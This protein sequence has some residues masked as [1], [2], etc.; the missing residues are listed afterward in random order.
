MTNEH[1]DTDTPTLQGIVGKIDHA[2]TSGR[3]STGDLAELRRISPDQPYTPALWKVLLNFVPESWTAGGGRDEKERRWAT[4]LMAMGM[5]AGLHDPS[6]RFG[7]ALARAG[8]S[9]L[10]FVRL[11]RARDE[12]LVEEM[13]RLAGFMSSKGA[14]ANWTDAAHLLFEQEGDWAERHR[15]RIARDYYKTVF[16]LESN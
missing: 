6:S 4:L 8:F 14:P 12:R 9:E 2:M 16:E 11:L 3:L 15:R 5:N 10:R 1:V 7:S 13:R